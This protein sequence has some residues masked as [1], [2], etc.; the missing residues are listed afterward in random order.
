MT[1][2]P[3]SIDSKGSF[4][5]RCLKQLG[6]TVAISSGVTLSL[7]LRAAKAFA[8]LFVTMSP[9]NPST[10]NSAQTLEIFTLRS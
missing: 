7:P 1:S 9:L 10:F 2:K 4:R 6:M 3:E 5:R 8:A